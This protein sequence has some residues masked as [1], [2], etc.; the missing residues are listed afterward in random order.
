MQIR[1]LSTKS[2]SM[3]ALTR[4]ARSGVSTPRRCE[5]RLW[6]KQA[7]IIGG[8]ERKT[9]RDHSWSIHGATSV[10]TTSLTAR[11]FRCTSSGCTH[12]AIS[13]KRGSKMK[14][15]LCSIWTSSTFAARSAITWQLT[16]TTMQAL[17]PTTS[18]STTSANSISVRSNEMWL[19]RRKKNCI[20]T[21]A[22]CTTTRTTTTNSEIGSASTSDRSLKRSQLVSQASKWSGKRR[23]EMWTSSKRSSIQHLT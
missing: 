16:L 2:S 17:R 20:I 10:A 13:A 14:R 15:N 5:L 1:R 8:V 12:G 7:S 6:S 19:S 21:W 23:R 3:A 22:Q 9:A 11:C 18:K 4:Y